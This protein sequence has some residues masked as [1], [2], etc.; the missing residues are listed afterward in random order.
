MQC[1]SVTFVP[2]HLNSATSSKDLFSI[3]IRFRHVMPLT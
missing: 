3:F 2:R 1:W